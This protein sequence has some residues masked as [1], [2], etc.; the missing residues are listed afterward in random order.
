MSNENTTAAVN[1]AP[2]PGTK[3]YVEAELTAAKP[4]TKAD[5]EAE[6]AA[7]KAEIEALKAAQEEKE[8]DTATEAPKEVVDERVDLFVEKGYANDEPNLL[9]A[10]NGVNYVLPKGKTSKVPKHVAA[11]YYRSR[12]AQQHL[13]EQVDKLLAAATK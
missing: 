9:I 2:K 8:N 11:E 3:A 12:K 5:V 13:D 7:A 1:E 6:L 4:G 10:V